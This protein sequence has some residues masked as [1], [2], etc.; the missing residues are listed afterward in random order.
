M[1]EKVT[2]Q[3]L[4]R[5]NPRDTEGV[6]AR[7][8]QRKFGKSNDY[9]EFHIYDQNDKLLHTI[10]DYTDYEFPEGLESNTDKLTNTLFVDPTK[11]LTELGFNSGTY[12]VILNFQRKK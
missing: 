1:A 12:S 6:S 9:V 4:D 7:T 5:I 2:I 11:T 8:I 10:E 3:H